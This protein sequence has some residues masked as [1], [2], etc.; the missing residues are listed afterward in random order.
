MPRLGRDRA[1]TARFDAAAS[2]PPAGPPAAPALG[3]WPPPTVPSVTADFGRR[4][5]GGAAAPD[6]QL[7]WWSLGPCALPPPRR[8]RRGRAR[9]GTRP[10]LPVLLLQ[11]YRRSLGSQ[12]DQGPGSG[13]A[14]AHR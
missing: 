8:Y 4:P 13:L 3:R 12:C 2:E 10:T 5:R 1:T 9:W 14:V 11:R 6:P 7:S